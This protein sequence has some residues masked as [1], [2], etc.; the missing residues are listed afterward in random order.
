M[1]ASAPSSTAL[2]TSDAS[3]LVGRA[4][5]IMESSICVATMIDLAFFLAMWMARF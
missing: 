2:A 3:A 4:L 1:T 5:L